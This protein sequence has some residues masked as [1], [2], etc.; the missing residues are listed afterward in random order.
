M[1]AS[2]QKSAASYHYLALQT[3]PEGSDDVWG[4]GG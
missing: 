1:K 4:G 3:K 2:G